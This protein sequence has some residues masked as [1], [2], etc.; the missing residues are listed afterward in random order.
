MKFDPFGLFVKDLATKNVI[1]MCN[2]F[3]LL[4]TI[5]LSATRSPQASTCYALAAAAADPTL[6]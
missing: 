2:S 1:A 5:R 4:Y 3:G 6:L